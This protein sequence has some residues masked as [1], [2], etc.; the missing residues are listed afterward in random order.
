MHPMFS[1]PGGIPPMTLPGPPARLPPAV[2]VRRSAHAPAPGPGANR[3]PLRLAAP[4]SPGSPGSPNPPPPPAWMQPPQAAPLGSPVWGQPAMMSNPFQPAAGHMAPP[5]P[6]PRPP[7]SEAKV[8]NSAFTALDPLGE[9]E[10]KT[11]K[12]MFKDFQIVKPP[13]IPARKGEQGAG[14]NGGGAFDQYFSSKVGVPQEVADFDDF[15]INRISAATAMAPVPATQ[16]GPDAFSP[17]PV[18][19]PASVPGQALNPNIFDDAFGAPNAASL[20]GAP[21]M[22]MPDPPVGQTSNSSDAFGDPFGNPF[23]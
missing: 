7:M 5:R 14:S 2:C 4:G 22:A 8:E 3:Y 18:T 17:C 23:A 20:F 10:K 1:M 12:D 21:P 9:K 6:P 19:S 15:D 13:A 11:G 16:P